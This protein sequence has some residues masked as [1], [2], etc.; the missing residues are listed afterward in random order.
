M[1]KCGLREQ[2]LEPVERRERLQL[3]QSAF[4]RA[5]VGADK[6]EV[7]LHTRGQRFAIRQ[8]EALG[9]HRVSRRAIRGVVEQLPRHDLR[10]LNQG[11]QQ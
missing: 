7:H 10:G 9:D 8:A 2:H 1:P 4:D 11:V 5:G 6:A 3:Y